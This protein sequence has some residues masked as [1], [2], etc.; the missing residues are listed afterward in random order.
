MRNDLRN[1]DP[2]RR[3]KRIGKRVTA[4]VLAC[5]ILLTSMVFFDGN[6]T[7]AQ[8]AQHLDNGS[9]MLLNG[10]VGQY[11]LNYTGNTNH[12]ASWE[13]ATG[14]TH[15]NHVYNESPWGPQGANCSSATLQNTN[16]A[17]RIVKA[18]L[19]W[20]TRAKVPHGSVYFL[21]Y[22]NGAPSGASVASQ[23]AVNDIRDVGG[24]IYRSMYVMAAD[25]TD[26]VATADN[27]GYGT[28]AV[29]NIPQFQFGDGGDRGGGE[30]PGSWQ[31]VVVEE[32][33]NWRPKAIS[34]KMMSAFTTDATI[35][36]DIN[37]GGYQTPA[38]G[39]IEGQ[40]FFGVIS[41]HNIGMN[42]YMDTYSGGNRIG[43]VSA[44]QTNTAGL[45][46]NG[47]C[48]N[49]RDSGWSDQK[50]GFEKGCVR[51]DL[52]DISSIGNNATS[53][54]AIVNHNSW[55]TLF[56]IG[57]AVD[58]N[59]P[60]Y[61]VGFDGNGATGGSMKDEYHRMDTGYVLPANKFS[62]AATIN[63]NGNGGTA[64]KA[65]EVV[66]ST[67]V[68]WL[69]EN[70]FNYNG[71]VYDYH[72]FNAPY[73]A[74][75]YGDI[76]SALGYNKM[77]LINHWFTHTVKGVEG[78]QSSKEFSLAYYKQTYQDLIN[79]YGNDNASYVNHYMLWGRAE[80]RKGAESID[81]TTRNSYENGAAVSNLSFTNGDNVT[82]KAEWFDNTIVL[83]SAT[84]YGYKFEGWYDKDGNKIGNAGDFYK[85]MHD[86]VDLKWYI[87][88]QGQ[89]GI[90][91]GT[92]VDLYYAVNVD[93][94][95]N[96]KLYNSS[97]AH[98][99]TLMADTKIGT[100]DQVVHWDT[101]GLSAGMYRVDIYAKDD[102]GNTI[103]WHRYFS[104]G[105]N[106]D[107]TGHD[108][109]NKNVVK[110]P[111]VTLTAKWTQTHYKVTLKKDTGIDKIE[112]EGFTSMETFINDAY[113]AILHRTVDGSGY[114]TY[115]NALLDGNTSEND[116]VRLVK[117][118]ATSTEYLNNFDYSVMSFTN[119]P[120]QSTTK[121]AYQLTA[122]CYRLFLNRTPS[123]DEVNFWVK[124]VWNNR[125]STQDGLK[126]IVEGI[127]N[128]A[129]AK[130]SL[131]QRYPIE[132]GTGQVLYDTADKNVY[133]KY[134]K[135]G[136]KITATATAAK[137]YVFVG[138]T[139]TPASYTSTENPY[140][141]TMPSQDV[142]ITATAKEK[143]KTY[144]VSFEAN[145]GTGT[146]PDIEA[147]Y[148]ENTPLPANKFKKTG[149]NV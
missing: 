77:S 71:T 30:A 92:T 84:R 38:T 128:S 118:L 113:V 64:E 54:K 51:M 4:G 107:Y 32:N 143:P 49:S 110:S 104:I 106:A 108:K 141:F 103:T 59:A 73:Y 7:E 91:A 117:Q 147:T 131:P 98:I 81:T 78:R 2:V 66:N 114:K 112:S 119:T 27:N 137:D 127:G 85:P 23:Y 28:Y 45:Y 26:F 60:Y 82:L 139:G 57:A 3:I 123:N 67:F 19:V 144:T 31:L 43:T 102:L 20:E 25:V 62:R 93:A 148:D 48:F 11:K 21:R 116:L 95:A 90:T 132:S 121:S 109:G 130:V 1:K 39:N 111:A 149:C 14:R 134:V 136:T 133:I 140:T 29:A 56:M 142:S 87:S 68:G 16:G 96:C 83:P 5:V 8:A 70:N 33:S 37:F 74:N 99:K 101:S 79:A 65:S 63:Y 97:G 100:N 94:T 36:G 41:A 69:D 122:D 18:Y 124:N 135:P 75:R 24:N 88:G 115:S 86:A 35:T 58:V 44:H 6:M 105:T 120:T 61:T 145:G 126:K 22:K 12:Y 50:S 89:K 17:S 40:L 52:S 80:G 34:L 53:A 10:L 72:V 42:Q 138:W 46:R 15:V 76:K 55:C 125:T 9:F 129:E 146:M 13:N 47:N